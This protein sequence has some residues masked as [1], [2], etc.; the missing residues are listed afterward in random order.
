MN[1]INSEPV[2]KINN[3]FKNQKSPFVILI[4]GVNG[5][6]KTTLA[7]N[8]SSI[9]NIKQRIGLGVIVKT[10]IANSTRNN[11]PKMIKMDNVFS[12]TTKELLKHEVI[13]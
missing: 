1:K 7:F 10:L 6:G 11:Y 9:L 5:I 12:I 13:I 4:C 8:L 2:F 3:F